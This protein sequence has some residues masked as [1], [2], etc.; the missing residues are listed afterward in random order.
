LLEL[1]ADVRAEPASRRPRRQRARV[2]QEMKGL[3]Q[4]NRVR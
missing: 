2:N 3:A 4:K 1:V